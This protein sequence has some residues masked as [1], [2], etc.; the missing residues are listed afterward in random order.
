MDFITETKTNLGSCER[1]APVV[2]VKESPEV[3]EDTLGSLR[4]EEAALSARGT[5]L[6]LEHKVEGQCFRELVISLWGLNVK[7]LNR[8][9]KLDLAVRTRVVCNLVEASLILLL[10]V[11]LL[12]NQLLNMLLNQLVRP[13]ALAR[14]D[15][16]D[17]EVGEL[18]NVTLFSQEG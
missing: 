2:E 9:V 6:C 10:H 18:L 12:G 17:H 16:L 1:H 13:V 8:G 11:L 5:N 4:S 3:N 14:L 15:V 7:F